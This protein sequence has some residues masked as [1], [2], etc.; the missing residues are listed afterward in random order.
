M[1]GSVSF[2]CWELRSSGEGRWNIRGTSVTPE[3]TSPLTPVLVSSNAWS[4]AF[5]S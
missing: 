4:S 2:G 3:S 5:R 1:V